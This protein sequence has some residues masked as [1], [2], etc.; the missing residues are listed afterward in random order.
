M[1]GV[2]TTPEVVRTLPGDSARFN[3]KRIRKAR[4]K[5]DPAPSAGLIP[6]FFCALLYLAGIVLARFCYLKPAYL[7]I[8]LPLTGF[9][10][11]MAIKRALR[12]RWLPLAVIWISLGCWSAETER[13]PAASHVLLKLSD[14]L[15]RTVEG[16]VTEVGPVR[17]RELEDLDEDSAG[18]PVET[19]GASTKPE[20]DEQLQRVDLRTTSVEVVTDE[21]D[22]LVAVEPSAGGSLR[23]TV[24]RP[25]SRL[26]EKP[27]PITCG[28]RIQVVVRMLPPVIY[29]DQGVWNQAAYLEDQDISATGLVNRGQLDSGEGRLKILGEGDGRSF[30]CQV[31]RWRNLANVRL[32][33][34]PYLTRNLPKAFRAS[35]EDVSMLAALLT[36]DRSWLTREIRVGFERTG[37]F[38]LIVV[39]G[40]HLA[41][42]A[43]C[44]S[45][46]ARRLRLGRFPATIVTL[47]MTL[48]YALFTGFAIPAQRSFWMIALYLVG[49]LV[50]R[51]RS[52]LNVIGF[53]TICLAT[54]SPR[55][56]FDASLQM[57]L[58]SVTAIAGIAIP[59]LET[60]LHA[61]SKATVD[62]KLIAVD[63]RLPPK[64]AQFRV[65][66]RLIARHLERAAGQKFAWFFLP[67]AIRS[68]L[69]M[70]ELLFVTLMVEMALAL[71]MAVYFHRITVY[72]LPVNLLI[73]PLLGVLVP[74]AMLTLLVAAVFP[75]LAFLPASICLGALHLSVFV[76]RQLG[77]FSFGD[78]RVPEPSAVQVGI[79]L[80]M[81]VLA[82]LFA[83]GLIT[84]GARFSK[85]MQRC[86]AF[87]LLGLAAAVALWPR[88]I[89]H[90]R[91][92]LL[93][94]AIDVGQG[95][96]LLL[97]T[98]EG[99]TLL[100][101][102]GG[103]GF[104]GAG[105]PG[106]SGGH[107]QFDVGEEVVSSV[108]WARGI[109]RLDVVALTHGHHDHMGGLPAVLRN[110]RPRELW[111]GNNPRVPEYIDLLDEA[112]R[113]GVQV[114]S[115]R[116]GD[117]IRLGLVNFHVLAPSAQYRP[118][119]QPANNDSLVMRASFRETSILLTGD[120]EA[121]EERAI[122]DSN[123][124]RD[125]YST[126]LKV[127][128]HGSLTSTRANFLSRVKPS[129]AVI[130]CGLR[131]RFGHPREEILEELQSA[132]VR[133]FRTDVDG[134]S[135]LLLDGKSVH[136]EPMCTGLE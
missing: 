97:I 93:F 82:V 133:T 73:L 92:A 41:I 75:A 23:L 38:H 84:A 7:L 78:V 61:W 28:Q 136:A 18:R 3:F 101:D 112:V 52:P 29:H 66:V 60:N 74:A 77:Q 76:V 50:F 43:G 59:L 16:T 51:G 91:N 39:S 62:L 120:A 12:L 105:G 89:D 88:P 20:S 63:S 130:S 135:C 126:V 49:R 123:V 65:T 124:A 70:G 36:G 99:K 2:V 80:L 40:L 115:L 11:L 86:V 22:R 71:P 31:N 102:G 111:V 94:E 19:E 27:V 1:S 116:A 45:Y 95:D 96:S 13:E 55:S 113:L 24:A 46:A 114:R 34:L 127:G 58:L 106:R 87:S 81:F 25:L 21:F 132:G 68:G 30:S 131:N 8:S 56:I 108:L 109:R 121:P 85:A 9:L 72:A 90:P 129:W 128:H 54:V 100:V 118:G 44:V 5:S 67:L 107:S 37:S 53:A 33:A 57:T 6:L 42:L 48:A 14:G 4:P 32:E 119:K 47:T 117:E 110:F 125:V 103:I 15:L 98:P 26:G 104:L 35:D 17:S 64:I 134:A 122:L 79:A 83:R 69:R 10:G